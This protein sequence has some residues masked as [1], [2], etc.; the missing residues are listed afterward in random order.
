MDKKLAQTSSSFASNV[1]KLVTGSVFAQGLGIL[2]IPIVARLF[3]PE[4]FGVA[5]LFASIT[6]IIGVLVCLRYEVSIMLPKTDEEAANLLG[7]S[8][9]SVLII[10]AIS[11]LI[12]LFA[13]EP[14]V[15]LLKAPELAKY[16]WLVPITVL[17]SGIFL[18]LNYWNSRTKHFGRLSIARV[19]SSTT[20]QVTKLGLGFAGYVS[21]GVLIGTGILGS[22]VSTAVLGGQVWTDDRRLFKGNIR[23]KK[24]IAGLK[25]YKKFPIFTTWSIL[26]NTVSHQAP[27]WVLAFFSPQ[28]W[29]DSMQSE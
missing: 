12:I 6:G 7:V 4:A 19:I 10:T 2:V 18:A 16:L 26:L 8:L 17:I 24:I 14:I 1:L 11:A 28:L 15:R 22:L 13:K 25:R 5:A 21:S 23:W 29:W 9:C 27:L 3:A 20:T